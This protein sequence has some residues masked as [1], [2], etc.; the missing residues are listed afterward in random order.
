MIKLILGLMVIILAGC[1]SDVDKCVNTS[2]AAWD[3]KQE[4]IKAEWTLQKNNKTD[5]NHQGGGRDL[6]LEIFG[7]IAKPDER[8]KI[9]VESEWRIYCMSINSKNR[10]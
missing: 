1:Q 6:S 9:E 3:V 10:F 2:L 4:R 5:T 8:S 7:P